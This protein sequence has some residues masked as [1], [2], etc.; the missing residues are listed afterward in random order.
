VDFEWFVK[1]TAL[2]QE[3]DLF[4][5]RLGMAGSALL[6]TL[7]PNASL[8]AQRPVDVYAFDAVSRYVCS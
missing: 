3:H 7:H 5:I 4:A 6:L 8:L 1:V 2:L